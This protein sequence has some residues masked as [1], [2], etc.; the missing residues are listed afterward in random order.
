MKLR[1]CDKNGHKKEVKNKMER[2]SVLNKSLDIWEAENLT[3]QEAIE[4]FVMLEDR[5]RR[6][7]PTDWRYE[8]EIIEV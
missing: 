3:K 2:Y 6:K 8:F 5:E 1:K 7:E 4:L